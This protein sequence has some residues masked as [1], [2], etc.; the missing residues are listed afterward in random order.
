[1][2][3]EIAGTT[4][5]ELVINTLKSCFPSTYFIFVINKSDC[6]KLSIN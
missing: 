3:L 4:M 2:S 1:M 6:V 5:I